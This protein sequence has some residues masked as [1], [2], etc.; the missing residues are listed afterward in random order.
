[1]LTATVSLKSTSAQKAPGKHV[2][3]VEPCFDNY[4][5][6]I[7]LDDTHDKSD[8]P[9]VAHKGIYLGSMCQ[10]DHFGSAK[11]VVKLQPSCCCCNQLPGR[12]HGTSNKDYNKET[13]EVAE[14]EPGL[15]KAI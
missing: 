4:I 2:L 9:E 7:L 11:P 15:I 8:S 3:N 5:S 1:M 13:W 12:R 10:W 14:S 6:L